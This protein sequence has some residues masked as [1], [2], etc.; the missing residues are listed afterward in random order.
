LLNGCESQT[1]APEPIA[2]AQP[3]ESQEQLELL[4]PEYV[5]SPTSV[6][7]GPRSFADG[8]VYPAGPIHHQPNSSLSSSAPP[9]HRRPSGNVLLCEL[10]S[11]VQ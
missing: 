10:S 2:V 5:I 8:S 1:K 4:T 7:D 3:S 11:M 9:L 6:D